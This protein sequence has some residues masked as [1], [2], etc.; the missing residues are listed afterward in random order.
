MR[1][2]TDLSLRLCRQWSAAAYSVCGVPLSELD[3]AVVDASPT[4][5]PSEGTPQALLDAGGLIHGG[6]GSGEAPC[7]A[8]GT[9]KTQSC[10]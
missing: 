6:T 5:V 7:T 10:C 8:C 4:G 9:C 1:T 2:L 3:V